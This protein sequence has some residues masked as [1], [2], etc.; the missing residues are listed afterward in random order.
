MGKFSHT[1]NSIKPGSSQTPP[2]S[3]K[4]TGPLV[5]KS[6]L[7]PRPPFPHL[8]PLHLRL[9]CR[10]PLDGFLELGHLHYD[11]L[12]R[13]AVVIQWE[14]ERG[15]GKLNELQQ[16]AELGREEVDGDRE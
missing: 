5:N 2:D 4:S 12:G 10:P 16:Q 9:R 1:Y 13:R 7:L 8:P 3:R 6:R 15:K 11:L 14:A